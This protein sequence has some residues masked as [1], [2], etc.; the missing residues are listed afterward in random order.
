MIW[1]INHASALWVP[2]RAVLL[3]QPLLLLLQSLHNDDQ[4]YGSHSTRPSNTSQG[5]SANNGRIDRLHTCISALI[6]L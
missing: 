4:R 6:A 1:R 3:A 5:N 2:F